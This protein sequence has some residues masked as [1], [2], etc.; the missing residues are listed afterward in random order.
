[1]IVCDSYDSG[2]DCG[3]EIQHFG[4]GAETPTQGHLHP[5]FRIAHVYRALQIYDGYVYVPKI[6]SD[7]AG[8]ARPRAFA[9]KLEIRRRQEVPRDANFA[10]TFSIFFLPQNHIIPA[11]VTVS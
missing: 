7:E 10:S 11:I 5:G 6:G 3:K 8:N 9:G 2:F 1:M 4:G